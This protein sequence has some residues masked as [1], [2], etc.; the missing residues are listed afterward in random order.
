MKKTFL[1]MFMLCL[2]AAAAIA[3][4][5][6]GRL[7]GTISGPD[8]LIPG[9]TVTVTDNQTGRELTAQSGDDGQF[10]F[11][12]LPFGT[13]TVR[14][15]A[16]GF[17][18][19]VATDVK[20]DANRDY[21]LKPVLEVGAVEAQVTV[22][23]GTD[24]VNSTN[25]EL[26]STVSPRQVLELPINGRN[27]LSLLNL[28]AGVNATS[29]SINGQRSSSANYTRDG[30]NVQDNY[31]RSGGFV[32]DRPS[33]DDTGEFTVVTQNAGAELGGG[34]SS[35]IRLVTPRGGRDFHGAAYIYNRNSAFSANT[36]ENNAAGIDRPFLNRNQFGGKVS[37]PLP[38]PGFGEGSPAF[39]TDKGFF[40][41]NYERFL[42][43]QTTP[44][45]RR[46][47]LNQF[48]NGEFTYRDNSGTIRTVNVL[49][50][51]GLNL[52]TP[53]NQTVFTNAGGVLSLDP[54]IQARFLSLTPT[55]GNSTSQTPITTGFVTQS[56]IFNQADNDTRDGLT[57]RFDV[58]AND[59]NNINFIYKWNKNADDRQSDTGG[60]NQQ[61]F[62]V[63]GGPT[64][65]YALSWNSTLSSNFTNE[66]R[67]GY[68]T[69]RPFFRQSPDF[70]TD[71]VVGGL[72]F[73]L[74]NPLPSFQNQGRNTRQTTFQDNAS[75]TR[76]NHSFRFGV[77]WNAQR[78]DSQTN[79][80][81]V[82]IYNISTTANPRTP[83]LNGNVFPG[84][85]ATADLAAANGLRY[86]LGGVVGSGSVNAN[87]V[88]A[89]TGPQIGAPSL[90]RFK[91]DTWGL[92]VSDQWRATS[93]LTLNLGLRW[94]YFTPLTN[95]D[96]VYLEPELNNINSVDELESA[97]LNPN[98]RYVLVGTNVGKPG[99]FFKGDKNN[100]GPVVSFAY[101]PRD[102]GGFIG[103]LLG[104]A[105]QTVIR[106]GFRMSYVNDEYIR[107]ADN[108]AAGNP[109]LGTITVAALNP[110]T[111]G[112]QLNSRFSNLPTFGSPNFIPP[113]ITFAQSNAIPSN[114][115]FNTIF[116]ID[117]NIETQQTMEYNIG[118]Q[119]EIGFD[120]AIEIRYVGGR[121][122]SLVRGYDIN[123]YNLNAA[124]G[125]FFQ[126]F[127]NARNN[128][129]AQG[130]TVAVPNQVDTI[131]SC[132]NAGYNQNAPTAGTV[133]L[134]VFQSIGLG[135]FL[136]NAAVYNPIINGDIAGLISV[137]IQNGLDRNLVT[138]ALIPFRPNPN[139]GAIDILTNGGRY[140]YNAL[141]MEIRRRFTQGFS[142]QA[143]YTFQ[144]ILAD[145]L[146]DQQNR[147]DSF[148]D[149]NNPGL[150][151][152]RPDYDRTHTINI[153]AIYE[154]PFGKNKPFLN[155]GGLV[156]AIFGGFQVTSII[157]ISSGA[158]I[159]IKD[160]NGTL[161][162]RSNRQ[163]A[164]S[165]LTPDQ[166]QDLIGIYH[167]NG[168]VYFIDPSV[169]GPNGSAT[170]SNVRTT[171]TSQFPG[172]VF[173]RAQPGQT[174]TLPRG[175]INGP[176][177]FNW[178]AGLIKNIAF[179]E[180][181]R[182]QLRAEAFNVLN[183]TNFFVPSGTG[184]LNVGEN[185]D[186]FNINSTS[187]G[188]IP[189][190]N[191]YG[192]RIMQFAVRFEF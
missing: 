44:I 9:A 81:Q 83:S 173:F 48:R 142:F 5:T 29:S 141:Q 18:T 108:A 74:S 93:E 128:C 3:Q 153:N 145:V 1:A 20:I 138:G 58:D 135:A 181:M 132:T 148:S 34:G 55:A 41:V 171:P 112:T 75:Y 77:D 24:I 64:D 6:N 172:Q 69:S 97:L 78:I 22:Q 187:F 54:T 11:D 36:F 184:A 35:Q 15:T 95:P 134:P 39:Y 146:A 129:R 65:L 164:N 188:Q 179:N 90:Q 86:L 127:L 147:F 161:T 169:I 116:A 115:F 45:T 109:G 167:L 165:S 88:N 122:N 79:F 51:A 101:S 57:M 68:A 113:P 158:P 100:F 111:N 40:F 87:F 96:Q 107:S 192:P 4:S 163:T 19:F 177:Y 190:S 133:P 105:N 71:F 13:Y 150:D 137:A 159:S 37:G 80:N 28:Q 168:R 121:S 144:K 85:I 191:N 102:R 33:V 8:G 25:A 114:A 103:A 26:S 126:D 155:Q 175:F 67:V 70:P 49:T 186:I 154:L 151:Y 47:L 106:G 61:P 60:F 160:I 143:N 118:I 156:N 53:A 104:D 38:L 117:P 152:S 162:R 59:R 180:R 66:A 94:D 16:A 23:A 30:I 136:N 92:Y 21:D 62:V 42:L 31:I 32:Q 7:V 124:G 130:A 73:G 12:Q 157:N 91:Y 76:G 139:A 50:G 149:T 89:S 189:L 84:G 46:V 166:I 131:L 63:Q 140:R 123:Q 178:D 14:V 27:P 119:R 182:V 110:L 185:S 82:P 174:G 170:N 98:G 99:Q 56:Y 72:P 2:L 43:R 125:A 176:W 183:R 52:S 17:K 10:R 120:T